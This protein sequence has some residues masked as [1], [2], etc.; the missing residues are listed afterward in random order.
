MVNVSG[1]TWSYC[2][3]LIW[4][5]YMITCVPWQGKLT[6]QHSWCSK[7]TRLL[8][9]CC[10][11]DRNIVCIQG[12]QVYLHPWAAL[13]LHS[14]FWW[15]ESGLHHNT[16]QQHL[17]A[18][19]PMFLLLQ[20]TDRWHHHQLHQQCVRRPKQGRRRQTHSI[21]LLLEP[22]HQIKMQKEINCRHTE[23]QSSLALWSAGISVLI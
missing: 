23:H 1:V 12:N 2:L 17:L 19:N 15:E 5:F 7:F 13:S 9:S 16:Q 6:I 11:N 21:N 22:C 8:T 4:N 18:E 20:S 10:N 3:F 14:L